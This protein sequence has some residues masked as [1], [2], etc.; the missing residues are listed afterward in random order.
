MGDILSFIRDL[1]AGTPHTEM[2]LVHVN[3]TWERFFGGARLQAFCIN[4]FKDRR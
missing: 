2:H 4:I 3:L 1:K